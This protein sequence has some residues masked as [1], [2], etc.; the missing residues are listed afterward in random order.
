MDLKELESGVDPKTHWYYQSKKI[1]LISF[2]KKI[3]SKKKI[4]LTLIDVGSGSGFFM[5]E[6]QE[7]IPEMIAKI[8]LVDIGYSD[9]EIASTKNQHIEKTKSLP[10]KI[11]NAVAVMMDVL[12][13][14]EDDHAMLN[15]IKEKSVGEN[16]YFITVPAFMSLW[17]GH[18]IYLGHYRRYTNDSL[19]KLLLNS[20]FTIYNRYYFYG[21][22]FPAV[23]LARRMKNKNSSAQ[24]DMK[25][26][27]AA[28]NGILKLVCT[29]E[30]PFRKLNRLW[31][32]S[33]VAE[34]RI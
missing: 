24:S 13:H 19:R 28:I 9:E 4:P 33:C 23:W 27:S 15:A 32:V 3:Y 20:Q 14:L 5:Y 18:D 10:D 17:S 2:V 31:G 21:S 30:I 25:P 6:L 26:M 22:I 34:G 11:E 29:I 7:A 8:Y 1:P 16:F 12:E